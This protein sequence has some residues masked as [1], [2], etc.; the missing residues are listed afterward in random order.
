MSDEPVGVL[1]IG[2]GASGAAFAWSMADSGMSVLCLEQGPWMRQQDYPTNGL[3]WEARAM[4]DFSVNPNVR[5]LPS[6]YPINE[7]NS[8]ISPLM[9]NAVGGSTILWAGHFPRLRPRDFRVRTDDGVG[10]DWPISYETLEPFFATN[11]GM[12]GVSGMA[13]DP[14]YPYH[15]PPLPPLPFGA[16]GNR[17]A[18]GFEKLGWHWWPSDSAIISQEYHG[19]EGLH[20]PRPLHIR[21]FAGRQSEHGYHLLAGAA[22]EGGENPHR[23]PRARNYGARRWH[24]RWR[25]LLRPGRRTPGAEGRNRRDGVQRR[26][27]APAA[28]PR[29][30]STR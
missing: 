29:N 7:R 12:M 8:P 2:A 11:D 26:R 4:G 14:A 25:P 15:E 13:G 9:F 19:R 18:H 22:A 23:L 3:D 16:T 30:R 20:Q 21:V 6:D 1:V 28:A 5:N 27:D 24:G 17:L 10:E